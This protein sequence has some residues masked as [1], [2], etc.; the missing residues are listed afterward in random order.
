MPAA[1]WA[2]RSLFSQELLQDLC[3]REERPWGEWGRGRG[4]MSPRQL[5]A[6]LKPFGVQPGSLRDGAKTGKGYTR[7][8]FADA[9]S[10]YLP[11]DPSHPS[12]PSQ[13]NAGAG[14]E[15]LRSV[16]KATKRAL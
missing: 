8:Q 1:P 5:A 3:A 16:T 2:A 6:R 11:P 15:D 12:H 10:R 13:I 9:F 14:L 4:S 7:E